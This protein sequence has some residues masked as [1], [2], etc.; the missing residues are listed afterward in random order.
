MVDVV[1]EVGA[2]VASYKHGRDSEQTL[3]SPALD[4]LWSWAREEVESL[5]GLQGSPAELGTWEKV[6]ALGTD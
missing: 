4:H 6:A 1:M 5:A 3:E 2:Q